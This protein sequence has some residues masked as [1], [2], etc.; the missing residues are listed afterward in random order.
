MLRT[1]STLKILFRNII[2]TIK[3]T[4][5]ITLSLILQFYLDINTHKKHPKS[6]DLN[7]IFVEKDETIIN[8]I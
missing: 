8:T 6:K 5:I 4:Y 1:T 3:K 2:L 7:L